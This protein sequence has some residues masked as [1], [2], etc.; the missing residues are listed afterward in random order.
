MARKDTSLEELKKIIEQQEQEIAALKL[1]NNLMQQYLPITEGENNELENISLRDIISLM[2]G[3]IYWKDIEGKYLGCNSYMLKMCG[4]TSAEQIIG[5]KLK[6]LFDPEIAAAIEKN[7]KEVI[8]AN[9]T[10]HF[11]EKGINANFEPAYFLTEKTPLRN[12]EGRP[13]GLLGMSFD[14]TERKKIEEDLKIAKEK[15]EASSRAKSQFLAIVNHELRTPLASIMGLVTILK[16]KNSTQ[17]EQQKVKDNIENCTQYLLSLIDDVLDFSRLETGKY[18]LHHRP[19]NVPSLLNE[20]FSLLKPIAENKGIALKVE[21]SEKVNRNILTDARILRQILINLTTNALKYTE[22]GHVIVQA[23]ANFTPDDDMLLTISVID[24]GKGIPKNK[25]DLIFEPFQQLEDAYTR[26]SSRSGTGLGLAIVK[27]LAS[28]INA[29]VEVKS[30]INSGS[31]FSIDARFITTTEKHFST[32]KKAI[33]FKNKKTKTKIKTW[34]RPPHILLIEDDPIVQYIHKKMLEDLGCNV[35]VASS[36]WDAIQQL[37]N[38]D[39][40]FVDISLP[41][42]SGF[43]VIKMIRKDENNCKKPIVALTA[44]NGIEE[45]TACL[46]AGANAFRNKPISQVTLK[47]LLGRYLEQ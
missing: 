22:N 24:T 30:K 17:A 18:S 13:I 41:D 26:Q 14:I 31:V 28:L 5:K 37:K 43:D 15:A 29:K 36:G 45:K 42:I 9:E 20:V 8:L 16:R 27:K 25:F 35:D 21:C 23:E 38:H 39:I 33:K 44:Y 46:K 6:D 2:P 3:S 4:F 11:E 47:K 32:T 1:E 12:K 19:L 34:S 7:D 40:V 10:R